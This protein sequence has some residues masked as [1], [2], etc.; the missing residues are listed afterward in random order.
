MAGYTERSF[1]CINCGHKGIPLQRKKNKLKEKFH[2]KQLFCPFCNQTVNHVE[3]RNPEEEQE[4]LEN[5]RNGV[6]K[7]EAEESLRYV[8]QTYD[9]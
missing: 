3:I 4:F 1:Y 5:F 6:Y 7:D 2:R 9:W 8:R